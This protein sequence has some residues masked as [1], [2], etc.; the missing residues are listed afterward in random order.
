[1]LEV[2][3]DGNGFARLYGYDCHGLAYCP[4]GPTKAPVAWGL[5]VEVRL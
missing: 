4:Y 2:D 5:N 1:M 3:R